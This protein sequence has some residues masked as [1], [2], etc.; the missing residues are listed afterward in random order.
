M[1]STAS[2]DLEEEPFVHFGNILVV[3]FDL[4]IHV[5]EFDSPSPHSC[6]LH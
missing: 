3:K 6:A 5:L 4:F 2:D 1:Y